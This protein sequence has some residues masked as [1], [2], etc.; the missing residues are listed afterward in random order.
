[1]RE[2]WLRKSARQGAASEGAEWEVVA[3]VRVVVFRV[4]ERSA[5]RRV[6]A[7]VAACLGWDGGLGLCC[8]CFALLKWP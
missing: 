4:R 6:G 7:M 2:I 8:W 3:M 5:R 1:M